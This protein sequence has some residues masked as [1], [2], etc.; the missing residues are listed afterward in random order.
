MRKNLSQKA[1]FHVEPQ[2]RQRKRYGVLDIESDGLMRAFIAGA[3]LVEG[4]TEPIFYESLDIVLAVLFSPMYKNVVWYG[5][6]M[7]EYDMKYLIMAIKEYD[8]ISI[9]AST[10]ANRIIWCKLH[11]GKK[12]VEIRD[13]LH[14]MNMKLE[15][16]G[17]AFSIAQKGKINFEKERFD[18]SNN[19][20][21][22]YLKNDC[23]VLLQA[24][25]S[26]DTILYHQ[27]S[28]HLKAT[29]A[30]TALSC[31]KTTLA[32]N[33][34]YWRQRPQVEKF[35]REGYFGG[36]VFLTQH[37]WMEGCNHVDRNAHYAATMRAYGIP[38]GAALGTSVEYPDRPGMYRCTVTCPVD[39]PFTFIPVREAGKGI[40]YPTGTF[41]TVLDSDTLVF[42]RSVGYTITVIEGYVWEKTAPIFEKLLALCEAIELAH[43]IHGRK[44]AIAQAMKLIRNALYGIFGLWP[45]G[46][47][48]ICLPDSAESPN[49]PMVQGESPS[50]AL[51]NVCEQTNDIEAGYIQPHW[52]AWI[53]AHARLDLAKQIYVLGPQHVIYGD[54]DS[55]VVKANILQ[56]AVRSGIIEIGERYGQWKIEALYQSFRALAPKN[57]LAIAVDGRPKSRCKGI[58]KPSFY[59]QRLSAEGKQ[60]KHRWQSIPSTVVWLKKRV[61]LIHYAERSYSM[62]EHSY[63]WQLMPDDSV[64]PVHREASG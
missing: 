44:D 24:L 30:S 13:S 11:K 46:K 63:A 64:R 48:L 59:K 51:Y 31:F 20:H 10:R 9:E 3:C 1:L 60:V 58:G 6:N 40:S 18:L 50:D 32:D 36:L 62:I 29:M 19:T 33:E 7:M 26:L 2:K 22:E 28:V 61:P 56:K 4:E 55:L 39:I 14:L 15:E 8:D 35:A 47:K 43:T 57:Y 41:E 12:T 45:E 49:L 54:T 16:I 21:R 37:K 53:T 52:A 34:I 17:R 5:H 25:T 42:A 23:L 27:F 38:V